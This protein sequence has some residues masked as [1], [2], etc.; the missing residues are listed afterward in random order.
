MLPG[1]NLVNL[2]Q[3]K[4]RF[5]HITITYY[6]D[7]ECFGGSGHCFRIGKSSE[8]KTIKI[9]IIFTFSKKKSLKYTLST[10]TF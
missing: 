5:A 6:N 4:T 8:I 10:H 2:G 9:V 1:K 7:F 3:K